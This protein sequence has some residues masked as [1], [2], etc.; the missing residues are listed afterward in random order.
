MS[1][2]DIAEII[3]LVIVVGVSVF[4]IVKVIWLDDKKG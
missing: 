2:V 1:V 4:G 3:F